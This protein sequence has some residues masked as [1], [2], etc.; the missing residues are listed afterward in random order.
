MRFHPITAPLARRYDFVLYIS[1]N[2]YVSLRRDAD[3]LAAH[4]LRLARLA[5]IDHFPY[6]PHTEC[7]ACFV[8]GR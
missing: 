1:C 2:P 8:R 7:A 3:G 6:T 4:G 5:L